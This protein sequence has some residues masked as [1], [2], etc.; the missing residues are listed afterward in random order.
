MASAGRTIG[1]VSLKLTPKEQIRNHA[2]RLAYLGDASK[3]RAYLIDEY[4]DAGRVPSMQFLNEIVEQR[5]AKF[6]HRVGQY[7][8]R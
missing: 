6:V 1:S 4:G 5:K 7:A 3:I 8:R 2:E